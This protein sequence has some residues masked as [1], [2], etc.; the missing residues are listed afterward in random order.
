MFVNFV[1]LFIA[2]LPMDVTFPRMVMLVR[3]WQLKNVASSI[4]VTPSGMIM[5]VNALQ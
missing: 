5:L 1:Q 4:E 3:F 2:H